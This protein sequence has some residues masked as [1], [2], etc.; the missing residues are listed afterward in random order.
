MG[1]IKNKIIS[2]QVVE[3][4]ISLN[5]SDFSV[6]GVQNCGPSGS[7][8]FQSLL[9]SHPD[10]LS[11]PGLYITGY[12]YFW[13]NLEDKIILAV[14]APTPETDNKSIKHSRSCLSKKPYKV[15]ASSLIDK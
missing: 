10:I 7:L 1:D 5:D 12:Y 4:P 13:E 2:M 6:V 8:F 3:N 14:D 9:D 11:I 15:C